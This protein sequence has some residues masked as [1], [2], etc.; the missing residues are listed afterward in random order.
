MIGRTI[1]HYEVLAKLGEG[2]MGV[3]YNA[4]DT[5]LNRQVALKALRADTAADPERRARFLQEA[6]AASAL[7]HPEIVTI[8][9]V[10]KDDEGPFHLALFSVETGERQRLTTPPANSLGDV[11]PALSPDGRTLTLYPSAYV[12]DQRPLDPLRRRT[13]GAERDL[14]GPPRGRGGGR[15]GGPTRPARPRRPVPLLLRGGGR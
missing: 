6:Q 10:L 9:D 5:Q 8:H 1:S 2:G 4:R 13:G 15:G 14:A 11:G 3:V 12:E 7:N